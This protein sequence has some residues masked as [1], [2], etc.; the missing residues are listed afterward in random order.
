M[1]TDLRTLLK[2]LSGRVFFI[3][4][5]IFL[6][7]SSLWSCTPEAVI[8]ENA[9]L[10]L[11]FDGGTGSLVEI[12]NKLT[13]ERY[14]VEGDEFRIE[15]VEFAADF[16]E[17]RP[18]ELKLTGNRFVIHYTGQGLD[19]EVTWTL[20][21]DHHFA[22][23]RVTLTASRGYGLR[24]VVLSQPTFLG[25]DLEVVSY[26]YPQFGRAPGKEPISTF[27]GRTPKGGFFTGIEMPFDVSSLNEQHV[28][29]AYEPGIK[30]AA[31]ERVDCE[32]VYFGVYERH[33]GD[34]QTTESLIR[35][36]EKARREFQ[37]AS[38]GSNG[39][40]I[41]PFRSESDAMTSMSSAILGPPRHGLLAM[42]NG[43]HSEMQHEAYTSAAIVEGEMASLDFIAACGFEWVSASHPWG[44][45]IEKMNA[46]GAEDKYAPGELVEKFLK[47]AQKKDLKVMMW[48]TMNHT[49][50][51]SKAGAP[52]RPDKP[53]WLMVPGDLSDKP[54]FVK[55]KAGKANCFA[56][57]PFFDWLSGINYEALATGYYPAWCMDGSFFG[58]GGW[59]TSVV[60]VD[61]A[62]D[63]HDH[64]PG[65]SNYASQRALDRLIS[66]VRQRYP[67]EFIEMCRP[68]MDLGVWS[69]RN[70]DVCFTQLEDGTG[71]DHIAAGDNI[72]TWSRAR[73]HLD[74]FPHYLDQPLLFSSRYIDDKR[75]FTWSGEN[76]DYIMLS[77]L[78]SAPSQL[79]Y[80]PTKTG[81]PAGD[82]AE[83]RKWL[84]WGR[85]HIDFLKVRKDLPDWPAP[86]KVDGSAHIIGD[87]G[88]VFL[89]NPGKQAMQ[90]GFILT[91][92][93]I[94]LKGK[95][96]FKVSQQYPG[97]GNSV[98]AGY[99]ETIRWEIPAETALVLEIMPVSNNE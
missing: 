35:F 24:K 59:Y 39:N 21:N 4:P 54:K 36:I 79:Y 93:E 18:T 13:N 23:K 6:I 98:T 53:E 5:G 82:K 94:G 76:L 51:W 46:L 81:I 62:S 89:F 69:I 14:H 3:A 31:N 20:G 65:N 97:S 71:I 29:L 99:G 42:V 30:V 43:W 61:C 9:H 73:V 91:D 63:G 11:S 8:L 83:I 56:H 40:P 87:K 22:E 74:F 77:G 90:G 52:F 37:T 96:S 50:P 86:G 15:A 70:V 33:D 95:G 88:L 66:G 92:K 44:G 78:S 64:L 2:S 85:V 49:H 48:P 27:F 7:I 10:G 75:P 84:D 60:P 28:L 80:L 68:P 34:D 57:T 17:L 45:E 58:D 41:V 12:R 47:H 32:P 1:M 16:S 38:A 72:R 25:D 55:E 67:N 26:R 19:S